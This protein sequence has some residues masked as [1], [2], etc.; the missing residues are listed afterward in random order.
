MKTE[1]IQNNTIKIRIDFDT[2]QLLE[3]ARAYVNLDKSKFIR[4]SIQEKA[5][6]IIGEHETTR[7]TAE[8]WKMFFSMVDNPPEPTDRMKKA[9]KL[10]KK[11]M[12]EN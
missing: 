2:Q 7:F 1:A 10:Y 11:I 12:D 4:Q 8:D 5:E 9:A 3:Q 6:A